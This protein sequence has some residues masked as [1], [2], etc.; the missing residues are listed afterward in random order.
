MCCLQA[1]Q[2]YISRFVVL[3]IAAYR[4]AKLIL[5]TFDIK[6][7]VGNLEGKSQQISKFGK[8][9]KLLVISTGQMRTA[10][11]GSNKKRTGLARMQF[12]QLHP[13]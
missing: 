13:A 3:G 12:A 10:A 8:S 6:D 4:L 9:Q 7:I 2:G 1:V 5:S 11:D